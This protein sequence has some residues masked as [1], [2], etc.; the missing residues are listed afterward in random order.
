MEVGGGIGLFTKKRLLPGE[1][2]ATIPQSC[3]LTGTKALR[4]EFGRSVVE[5]LRNEVEATDEFI[6]LLWMAVGR[7]D[8]KH[9]FHPYLASLPQEGVLPLSW[10][11]SLT[12]TNTTLLGTNLGDALLFHRQLVH[13]TYA[14]LVTTIQHASPTL[15]PA[16]YHH[17]DIV[18]AHDNYVSRRFPSS[19]SWV[20]EQEQGEEQEQN[21]DIVA[22]T[23]SSVNLSLGIML[24]L[25]DLANHSFDVELGWEGNKDG[26]SFVCGSTKKVQG[27]EA[28][29][30]VFNHYGSKGNEELMTAHGFAI[31]NNKHDSYGLNLSMRLPAAA[32]VVESSI[33]S[34][35]G[36]GDG[37][38]NGNGDGNG[39]GNGHGHGHGNGEVNTNLASC[40]VGVF[41]I[42][43]SDNPDVVNSEL[44]QIPSELWRAVCDPMEYMKQ[45]Q[46]Q[47]MQDG[48]DQAPVT[49]DFEDVEML[50]HTLRGRLQPFLL[51]NT[52]DILLCQ[53]SGGD[54]RA[55]FVAVY[56]DGQRRVLE[57]VILVLEGMLGGCDDVHD[58]DEGTT[59]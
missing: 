46:E 35:L 15:L 48:N 17:Q 50:L 21:K 24:P 19:L 52:Q 57:D 2:V 51:T 47:K 45:Q 55:R 31:Y 33:D 38:G 8:P 16:S 49:V 5:I 41:W 53:A 27:V 18:W 22:S 32:A 12:D 20:Q 40:C 3:V 26:V 9:P 23:F 29:G 4:T 28:G 58:V 11:S 56:R 39:N 1:K 13:G 25:L 59:T 42:H 6:L 10:P 7:N 44:E 43:R 54:P 37:N 36:D 30:E 14:N 34:G